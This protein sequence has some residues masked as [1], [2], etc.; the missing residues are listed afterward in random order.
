[1]PDNLSVINLTRT[2][3]KNDI[4]SIRDGSVNSSSKKDNG[5]KT[6]DEDKI[7]KRQQSLS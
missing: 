5:Q 2:T 3:M 4:I 1:M 7:K 6:F